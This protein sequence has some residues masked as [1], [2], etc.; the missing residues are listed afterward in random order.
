MEGITAHND[1][2][3]NLAKEGKSKT[4]YVSYNGALLIEIK[5]VKK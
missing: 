1:G 5:S 2:L 3:N 4:K